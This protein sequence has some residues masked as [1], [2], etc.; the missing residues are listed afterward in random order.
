MMF[1]SLKSIN[2]KKALQA[3]EFFIAERITLASAFIFGLVDSLLI[4]TSIYFIAISVTLV[5]QRLI[6]KRYEFKESI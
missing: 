4:S 1:K 6:R 2:R 5:A 3:H